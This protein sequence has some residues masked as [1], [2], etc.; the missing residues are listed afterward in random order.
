MVIVFNKGPEGM[1]WGELTCDATR[2][3]PEPPPTADG[4]PL[5]FMLITPEAK[6]C[7]PFSPIVAPGLGPF[8]RSFIIYR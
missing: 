5:L 8:G 3:A 6:T 7:C 1:M 2:L 4:R